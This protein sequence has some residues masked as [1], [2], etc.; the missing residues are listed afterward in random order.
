M[1]TPVTTPDALHE[2]IVTHTG[3]R[4]PRRPVCACHQAPFDYI[5]TAYFEPARD[6]VIWAPRGGG[7]T[8][9]AA[10]VTFLDLIHKPGVSIRILGGSLEQ[11]LR[12]WEYLQPFVEKL[13]KK[14]R[15]MARRLKLDNGSVAAVLTQ[16]QRSVRGQRVQKLRC[17]EVELFDPR[18]WEA[19]QLVTRSKH[20]DDGNCFVRGTIEAMSTLHKPFGLMHK[21]VEQTEA[22]L[23][24]EQT[25]RR[26]PPTKAHAKAGMGLISS[27]NT[28]PVPN[29]PLAPKLVR[30]CILDVLERCPSERDC[31]TCPLYDD[32]KGIA[33]TRCE[34][35]FPIDDAIVMKSRVSRETWDAEMLC[36]RPSLTDRVFTP[37]DR[38]VHVR[39]DPPFVLGRDC[40]WW[41]AI[42]FGFSNPFVCLWIITH[43]DEVYVIDEY[44]ARGRTID[45]HM[46][47]IH[48]RP[49]PRAKRI[50][51][52]P[53]GNGKSDQTARSNVDRLREYGYLVKTRGSAI[54]DGI[55]LIRAALRSAT[56]RTRLTFHPRCVNLLRAIQSYHYPEGGG[57][58]P[59]KDGEHDHPIDA[60][61]YFFANSTTHR[62]TRR[63]Y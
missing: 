2:W 28:S 19:A 62:I 46:A 10:V 41:L 59:V 38:D 27:T 49:W 58:L 6:Q 37:F 61:R 55:E 20:M 30:W 44:A 36:L 33:K 21:I 7:K 48:A 13:D 25:S 14:G 40:D 45:Q 29:T 52:D 54:V 4:V 11:S 60:L 22:R 32:C 34:G 23:A 18:V 9:L 47:E 63:A 1:L 50:A 3:L 24:Q 16:S 26:D 8:S 17:D 43:G 57:E 35:F 39:S 51:C 12:M 42:D 15:S 5:R 31:A 56:G 53:A